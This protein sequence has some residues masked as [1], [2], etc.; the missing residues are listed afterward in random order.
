MFPTES[1]DILPTDVANVRSEEEGE[2][3]I[4]SE[5]FLFHNVISFVTK[6][7]NLE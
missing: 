2:S 1:A 3:Q 4:Y 7:T 5:H 6:R